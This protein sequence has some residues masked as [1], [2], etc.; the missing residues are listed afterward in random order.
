MFPE[1]SNGK[2]KLSCLAME[3]V[4]E[5]VISEE[6]IER[7][8]DLGLGR[9]VDSTNP[10]PWINKSSFQVRNATIHN[11]IGTDEGG[12]FQS[13]RD[14]ASSIS[15]MHAELKASVLIPKTPL[16]LG[17]AA[18]SSRSFT[19]S[20]KIIGKKVINRTI[21]F[22]SDYIIDLPQSPAVKADQNEESTVETNSLATGQTRPYTFEETLSEWIL[23]QI[24]VR[25]STRHETSET[26]RQPVKNR[27]IIELQNYLRH[28]SKED[29]ARIIEDCAKFIRI[30]GITHYVSSITLGAV[31]QVVM[32]ETQY[33]S[34][35]K[36]GADSSTGA[37]GSVSEE[38]SFT[39][40]I[41]N[42]SR[43]RKL[44]GKINKQN[45]VER[46]TYD[47][48]V[49]SI[50]VQP[51]QSLVQENHLIHL[52]LHKALL[53]YVEKGVNKPGKFNFIT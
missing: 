53:E 33:S 6:E 28:A 52:A 14:I 15:E 12:V 19:S 48:A 4:V 21:S 16:L 10:A 30:F 38:L 44:I 17:V 9:G 18:E 20:R 24:D 51:L 26:E 13:F 29:N 11:L 8:L 31:E 36:E 47:E 32:S 27:P 7:F 50:R 5:S 43:N 23:K 40:K 35:V 37:I 42:K 25:N 2:G 3:K 22:R 39:D 46:R 34:F 41:L 45:S 1:H 49:V